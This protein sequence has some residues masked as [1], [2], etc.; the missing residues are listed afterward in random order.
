MSKSIAEIFNVAPAPVEKLPVVK[1]T[2][3]SVDSDADDARDNLRGLIKTATVA[4]ENALS[5]A[6]Q[7]EQP[8]AFEV[9][10]TLIN[11]ASDLN[12]KL[13]NTHTVQQKNTQAAPV[14]NTQN[15]STTNNVIF[16]GTSTELAKLLKG[17]ANE[18]K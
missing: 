17:N 7:S 9:V 11:A 2:S 4:L 12:T 15:N 18:I 16:N 1:T 5:I 3:S 6:V 13:L 8:R 10:A 14:N